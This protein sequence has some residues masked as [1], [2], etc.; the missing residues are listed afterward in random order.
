MKS[1][2]AFLSKKYCHCFFDGP[3]LV[4]W[5][6]LIKMLSPQCSNDRLA[7]HVEGS[8]SE[9]WNHSEL[10]ECMRGVFTN[11]TAIACLMCHKRTFTGVNLGPLR[12]VFSQT[13]IPS[14]LRACFR[15]FIVK[16]W[17]KEGVK[18]FIMILTKNFILCHIKDISCIKEHFV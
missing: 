16:F 3:R 14:C 4:A 17:I 10:C 9:K 18:S 2:F 15:Y 7:K 13:G 8:S 12:N 6:Q 1:S 11:I 5:W